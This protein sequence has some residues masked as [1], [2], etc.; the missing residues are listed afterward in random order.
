[1]LAQ[2]KKVG[3]TTKTFGEFFGDSIN[4]SSLGTIKS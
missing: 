1:M 4:L 3:G 2:L